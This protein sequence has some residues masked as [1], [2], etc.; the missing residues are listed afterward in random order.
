V[1]IA[2]EKFTEQRVKVLFAIGSKMVKLARKVSSDLPIVYITPGD[3]V[4]HGLVA[5]LSHPGGN[6]TAMTFEHPEL[7]GKRLEILM[8]LLP[9]VRRVL[10]LYDPRDGSPRRGA[11]AAR[12]AA[13][14]LGLTLLEREARISEDITRGLQDL[15][16]ADAFLSVPGG[17]P[18]GYY[19]EI[20]NAANAKKVPTIFHASTGSTK[21]ALISYGT[22]DADIARQA[23]RH[24]AKILKGTK[25][26]DLPVERPTNLDLVI[27]LRTAKQ[28]GITIPPSIRY[29]ADKVID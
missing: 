10:I 18:T 6:T 20:I 16:E 15:G 2:L 19:K 3:P 11:K 29:R 12:Q 22:S 1:R 24:V 14:N 23:A 9:R 27:N 8:Q 26:G 28:L 21:K 25:A 17:L 5:S 13:S 7:A 4:K